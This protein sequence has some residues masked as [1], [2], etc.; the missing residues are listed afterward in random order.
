MS[1]IGGNDC[2]VSGYPVI[3]QTAVDLTC[4]VQGVMTAMSVWLSCNKTNNSR[5]NMSNIGGTDCN[6]CLA[7]L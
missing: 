1:N 2:N 6:V 7:I 3:R 5:P 4:P